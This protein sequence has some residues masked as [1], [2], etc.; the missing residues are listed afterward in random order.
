MDYRTA[1]R[2]QKGFVHCG[3]NLNGTSAH[4][5]S[6]KLFFTVAFPLTRLGRRVN[7]EERGPRN[8]GDLKVTHLLA[9]LNHEE[10]TLDL[11]II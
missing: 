9:Y 10:R 8:D 4:T 1:G 11:E 7:D 2:I 3:W 6:Q 5:V